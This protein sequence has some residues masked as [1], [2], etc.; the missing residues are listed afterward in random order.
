M[1]LGPRGARINFGLKVD[2]LSSLPF[3]DVMSRILI[4][5]LWRGVRLLGPP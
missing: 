2:C 4:L 1:D 3:T 5:W